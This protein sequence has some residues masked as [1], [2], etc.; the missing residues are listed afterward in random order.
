MEANR[1]SAAWEDFATV[2]AGWDPA[3]VR[4]VIVDLTQKIAGLELEV[5]AAE[6]RGAAQAAETA[7]D[8]A[9]RLVAEAEEA[10]QHIHERALAAARRMRARA[11]AEGREIRIEARRDAL[12]LVKRARGD[13]DR[14]VATARAQ[15]ARL[16]ERVQSLQ[17]A[18]RRT[19]RL[20]REVADAEYGDPAKGDLS[21]AHVDDPNRD[22][23]ALTPVA[24]EPPPESV[25]R[26]LS[27]LRAIDPPA[28]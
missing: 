8:V 14:V 10:A 12:E 22:S 4:A 18:V 7:S 5:E 27:A 6:A 2:G 20:L 16:W 17:A 23:G 13:A 3:Q 25:R 19:E 24:S 9:G 11:A 28:T 15:E 21:P 1:T 26:L